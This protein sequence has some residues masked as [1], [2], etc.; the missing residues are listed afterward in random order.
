MRS[1]S[2]ILVPVVAILAALVVWPSAGGAGTTQ[3][4][5]AKRVSVRDDRFSPKSVHVSRGGRVTWVWR[6]E[7]D[8]NVRFRK[9]PSGAERPKGSSIQS[10]GRITRKFRRRGTYRYVCTLH[11]DLGMKGT[12]AVG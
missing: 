5:R 10:S 12:V 7:N 2:M 8:H 4:A 1:K 3:D 9:V 6:G 11:E